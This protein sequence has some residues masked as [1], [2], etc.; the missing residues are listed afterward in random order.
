MKLDNDVLHEMLGVG[1][2]AFTKSLRYGGQLQLEEVGAYS[3]CCF[4][5][6]ILVKRSM[7]GP[8]AAKR[9]D[10]RMHTHT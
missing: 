7:R 2:G 5:P 1:Y 8:T 10:T 9:G 3:F 6:G 4:T